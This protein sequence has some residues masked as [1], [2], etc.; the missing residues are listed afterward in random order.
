V[1]NK[2][3]GELKGRLYKDNQTTFYSNP[4]CPNGDCPIFKEIKR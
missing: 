3:I 2:E 4:E 1:V